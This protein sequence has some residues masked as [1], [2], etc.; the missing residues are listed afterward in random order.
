MFVVEDEA[1][2]RARG[3]PS[4]AR[5][6]GW[7]STQDA[8]RATAPRPDGRA[9]ARAMPRALARAR[10]APEAIGYV[11]AHGTGTPLN[12]PRRGAR[13][14]RRAR[15]A[16]RPRPG[17]LD[18]GRGR[19]PDGASGAI[20]LA[21]CLLAVSRATCLPGTAQPRRARSGVRRRRDRRGAAPARVD[22]VLSNSFGFGG[23]NATRRAREGGVSAAVTG[24]ALAHAAR[25]RRRRGRAP[26]AGG[27]AR[28][29]RLRRIRAPGCAAPAGRADGRSRSALPRPDGS[30]GLDA[31]HEAVQQARAAAGAG[32]P[33]TQRLGLFF[34]VGGLRAHWNET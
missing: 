33:A 2:A 8:Y 20:E 11:N 16:R 9:A 4:L 28:R 7:G 13:D 17:Q 32:A 22:V 26:A 34:G 19:P 27:R 31:A 30:S 21:A 10:V 23:Q 15:S 18:Q 6:L 25:Q 29:A 14:P 3:A 1:R 24:W 5:V 12:D